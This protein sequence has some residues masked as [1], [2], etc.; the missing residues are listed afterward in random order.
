MPRFTIDFSNVSAHIANLLG[1]G[2]R[3]TTLLSLLFA[4]GMADWDRLEVVCPFGDADLPFLLDH[5]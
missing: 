1:I 4:S 5:Y 3:L 2:V